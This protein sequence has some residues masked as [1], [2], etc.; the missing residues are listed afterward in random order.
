[1]LITPKYFDINPASQEG[2]VYGTEFVFNSLLPLEYTKFIWDFGDGYKKYDSSATSHTFSYPGIYTVSLSAWTDYGLIFSEKG[3]INVDYVIRDRLVF[4]KVPET[5]NLPGVINS[6]PFTISLTSSKIDQPLAVYLQAYYS[7][8]LP[9]YAVPSKWKFLVPTWK[10][11]DINRQLLYNN[12]LEVPTEPIYNEQ[13]K[14]V[15]VKGSASFY[16]ID[17]IASGADLANVCPLLLGATL[18][19]Q[20]FTYPPESIVYPYTSYSNNETVRAIQAWQIVDNMPTNLKVTENYI[21]DVYPVKWANVPIPLTITCESD[22]T[23]YAYSLLQGDVQTTKNLAYPPN[24]DIGGLFPVVATL[25]SNG[26]LD[27][28]VLTQGVHFS[29][30]Q[31]KYFQSTDENGNY[32]GGY[33]L[34]EI[35]PFASALTAV[36]EGSSFVAAVSCIVSN[37]LQ[38]VTTFSFPYRFPVRACTYVSN[39]I[40]NTINKTEVVKYPKLCNIINY[41][42]DLGILAEKSV[43]TYIS[44]PALTTTDIKQETLSGCS[45]VYGMAFNPVK[46]LFYACDADTGTVRLYNST[47]TLLSSIQL[48]S[49]VGNEKIAP[50]HVSIDGFYNVWIS[51]F[52][53]YKLLKFDSQLNYLLSACPS[54]IQELSEET[55]NNLDFAFFPNRFRKNASLFLSPPIVET[56]KYNFV[57]AI[58]S[59]NIGETDQVILSKLCHF[60]SRGK[61][62]KNDTVNLPKNCDPVSLA[63]DPTNAVWIACRGSNSIAKYD[64]ATRQVLDP[65]FINESDEIVTQSDLNRTMLSVPITGVWRPSYIAFDREAN[66]WITHGYD[67][68]SVYDAKTKQLSTWQF[69]SFLNLS[70]NSYELSSRYVPS[71]TPEMTAKAYTQ[72]EIWGGLSVDVYDRVWIIDSV[73]N[74]YGAFRAT[75]VSD[76]VT[77]PVLPVV[78]KHPVIIDPDTFVSFVTGG[79][80]RSAQ[81]GGD[82]TG[83]RWYQKYSGELTRYPVY[84][85]SAPFKIYDINKSYQ[86]AKVNETF[87]CAAYFRSLALPEVLN[88]NNAL[89]EQF[90]AAVAGEGNPTKES[91]GRVIYERIA[92]FISNHGDLDTAE[93]DQLHSFAKQVSLDVKTFGSDFPVGVNRLLNLFSIPKHNLRGIPKLAADVTDGIGGFVTNGEILSAGNFYYVKDK[94]FGDAYIIQAL[95]NLTGGRTFPLEEFNVAG[96]RNPLWQNYYVYTY[97]EQTNDGY[98]ANIIDWSSPYTTVS[99]NLSSEEDWYGDGGLVETMF[100]N[101]L[102]KQ[103]F[104]E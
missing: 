2:Q 85:E 92:N 52:D 58:W 45:S 79:D 50:S 27:G 84:G 82:W 77:I 6:I 12:L 100:N 56:D 22:P 4:S 95:P 94:D 67:L 1:M 55:L 61:E 37:A 18:S 66:L 42:E 75:D 33:V 89:F 87:D 19:T 25:S 74:S 69:T 54:E 47:N 96:L 43:L 16:Y 68:C 93:I 26:V 24:N 8:S 15:A 40:G 29:A 41:F 31:D 9:H 102:T 49:I 21:S 44:T 3:S 73:S 88:R 76:I 80:I 38:N 62:I 10:F 53:D 101:L 71:I 70:T 34:T 64:L 83:N 103:L 39:P 59:S 97:T 63:L 65:D 104:L 51:L 99:Y 11:L 98:V 17:D 13:N 60:D 14:I 78:E 72:N 23:R 91:A 90:F 81:A 86:I 7:K 36:K 57:W 28:V 30:Q 48:S 35:T 20:N 46:Q 32:V 5:F